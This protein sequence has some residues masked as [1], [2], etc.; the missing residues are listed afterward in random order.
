MEESRRAFFSRH[1]LVI[2]SEAKN[3]SDDGF[4]IWTLA[5]L[6]VPQGNRARAMPPT[7]L[8]GAECVSHRDFVSAAPPGRWSLRSV[9]YS[10][11]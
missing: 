4:V 6:E 8:A 2:P 10:R 5:S 7:H 9:K 3:F 1:S 11:E